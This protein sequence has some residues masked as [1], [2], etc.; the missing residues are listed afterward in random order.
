[1]NCYVCNSVITDSIK[2]KE[3]IPPRCIG[4]RL[5]PKTLLCRDCNNEFTAI[6]E[7]LCTNFNFITN[8]LNVKRDG[9]PRRRDPPNIKG[10]LPNTD[11]TVIFEPGVKQAKA[12][13]SVHK[14]DTNGSRSF[15]I[16]AATK[17]EVQRITN[18]LEQ[19][20]PGMKGRGFEEHKITQV[21]FPRFALG[22]EKEFRSVCKIAVNY[23]L[24]TG[25]DPI[26]IGPA[27]RYV[28]DGL[29]GK[30][31]W[32]YYPDALNATSSWQTDDRIFHK[33]SIKGDCQDRLLYGYVE[34][35][36]AFRYLVLLN[37]HYCGEN[38]DV[39][40]SLD[41]LNGATS[42]GKAAIE[43]SRDNLLNLKKEYDPSEDLE[44]QLMRL[45]NSIYVIMGYEYCLISSEDCLERSFR[46]WSGR[47][48]AHYGG[49]FLEHGLTLVDFAKGSDIGF[50]YEIESV[51]Y[52]T[53][54]DC[55][56]AGSEEDFYL[57][58]D[59]S[60][61]LATRKTLQRCP[62]GTPINV[63]L[64]LVFILELL[65]QMSGWVESNAREAIGIFVKRH[66]TS[67]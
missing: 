13:T 28:R 37:D 42:I 14:V 17:A 62:T 15:F 8:R 45:I 9:K 10:K 53:Y 16:T 41:I 22:T 31:V 11:I 27:I 46:I 23:Y 43:V 58:L 60:I 33:I 63:E 65:T 18:A 48:L 38:V 39:S 57:R 20:Y 49:D 29:G 64:L 55:V 26:L 32:F 40:Y 2:S 1:M 34:L 44:A 50:L 59:T 35:F 47:L 51:L 4:G 30:R 3:H 7:E 24:L 25:G 56:A 66:R 61:E 12:L 6:D 19:R 54:L 21:D 52:P 67:F 5:R 36:N